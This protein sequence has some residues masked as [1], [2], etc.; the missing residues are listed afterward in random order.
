MQ[1]QPHAKLTWTEIEQQYDQEWVELV[2]YEWPQTEAYPRS[3]VVYVHA[4]TRK[5]FDEHILKDPPTSGALVFVGRPNIEPG[6]FYCA[7][8]V[9]VERLDAD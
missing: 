5:E 3:G 7:N 1:S 6:T 2:D 8:V 9:R 4:K